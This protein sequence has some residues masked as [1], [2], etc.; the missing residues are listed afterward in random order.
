[1]TDNQPAL[2]EQSRLSALQHLKVLDSPFE[3]IFDSITRMLSDVCGMPIALISLVDEN[4]LWFKS[5]VGL[6]S[7]IE[8]P[9]EGS[10]CQETL[11]N[12]GLLEI[13]DASLDER[14]WDKP[15]VT[16]HPDLR[17]YCGVPI[18]LPM[19]EVIGVICV[20][21]LKPNYLN[22]YQRKT[23]EGLAKLVSQLLVLREINL[24]RN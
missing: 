1:M 6:E 15:M 12:G 21:D 16:G 7:F 23:I 18:K 19:G 20:L 3:T 4:R 2:H 9:R 13:P 5:N 22:E 24:K 8:A 17:F 11:Q 14:F 10:F